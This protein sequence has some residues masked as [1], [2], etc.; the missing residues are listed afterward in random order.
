MRR[1]YFI[2]TIFV[3]SLTMA[4]TVKAGNDWYK[5]LSDSDPKPTATPTHQAIVRNIPHDFEDRNA[6][7]IEAIMQWSTDP[8]A[9]EAGFEDAN[10]CYDLM[11]SHGWLNTERACKVGL[12]GKESYGDNAEIYYYAFWHRIMVRFGY[13]N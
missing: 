11:E 2:L 12:A 10:S 8:I 9:G 1:K 7:R 13:L 6:S 4:N 3:A 5:H